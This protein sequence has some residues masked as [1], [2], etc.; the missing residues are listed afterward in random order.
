MNSRIAAIL[1]KLRLL[2]DLP[3]KMPGNVYVEAATLGSDI[4]E[5]AA[6][7]QMTTGFLGQSGSFGGA[8]WQ[9]DSV[10]RE[11]VHIRTGRIF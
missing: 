1:H 4:G 2:S 10:D 5:M 3:G 11:I 6:E 9:P 7:H 8:P